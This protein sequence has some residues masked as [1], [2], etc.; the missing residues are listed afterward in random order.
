MNRKHLLEMLGILIIGF[1]VGIVFARPLGVVAPVATDSP[2]PTGSC[3]QRPACLD[4]T[5]R[6]LLPEPVEGWCPEDGEVCIQVI[7]YAKNP[8]TG[9]VKSFPTPCDVP[10]GWETAPEG[11]YYQEVQ[12]IKAPCYP[13][14]VCSNDD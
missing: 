11:C 9:E 12:C 4:S 2:Q 13:V 6:C 10:E 7:T 14:L 3:M 5:P 8:K 1:V